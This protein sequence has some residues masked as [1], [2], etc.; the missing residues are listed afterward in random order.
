MEIGTNTEVVSEVKIKNKKQKQKIL[1]K[2]GID[3]KKNER[4]STTIK[5]KSQIEE[6]NQKEQNE[7]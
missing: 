4:K 3:K 6:K 5:N 1:K 2:G 7:L